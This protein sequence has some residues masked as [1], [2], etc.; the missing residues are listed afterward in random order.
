MTIRPKTDTSS[1]AETAAK[2]TAIEEA[3]RSIAAGRTISDEEM[4]R[5]LGSW[6]TP[7]ELPPPQSR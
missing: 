4:R 3:R 2:R 1:S 5:W 7:S 6:G